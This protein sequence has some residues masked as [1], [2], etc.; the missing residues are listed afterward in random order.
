MIGQATQNDRP[1][2]VTRGDATQPPPTTLTRMRR[3]L[4]TL[5]LAATTLAACGSEPEQ[6]EQAPPPPAPAATTPAA[7]TPAPSGVPTLA[8]WVGV[9]CTP[10]GAKAKTSSGGDIVCKKTGT[11]PGPRWH[12]ATP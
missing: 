4:A 9:A 5:A 3:T 12:A 6:T 11:D 7:T 2:C 10:E 8:R 1:Q